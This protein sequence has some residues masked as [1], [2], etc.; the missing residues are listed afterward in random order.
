MHVRDRLVA[1][2]AVLLQTASEN[3]LKTSAFGSVAR[4]DDR[5]DGDIDF[6]VTLEAGRTLLDLGAFGTKIRTTR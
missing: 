1:M 6:L 3:G 2:R 5:A 4:G